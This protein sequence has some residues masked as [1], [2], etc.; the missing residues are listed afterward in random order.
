MTPN[1]EFSMDA[2]KR[3][4]EQKYITKFISSQAQHSYDINVQVITG[5]NLPLLFEGPAS[6]PAELE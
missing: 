2:R 4:T 5:M 6:P 1:K 3:E